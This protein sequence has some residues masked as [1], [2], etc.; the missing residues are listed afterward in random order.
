MHYLLLISTRTSHISISNR[1]S[2]LVNIIQSHDTHL[3]ERM[4][5]VSNSLSYKF[6]MLYVHNNKWCSTKELQNS[7]TSSTTLTCCHTYQEYYFLRSYCYQVDC[8]S[9]I[10]KH[11]KNLIKHQGI[12]IET[13]NNK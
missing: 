10:K 6:I 5:V 2:L 13:V 11:F 12:F 7:L 3:R 1:A 4:L 9:K 8:K